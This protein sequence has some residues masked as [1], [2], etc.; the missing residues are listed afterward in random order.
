MYVIC[1]GD[2]TPFK[3]NE[4]PGTINWTDSEPIKFLPEGLNKENISEIYVCGSWM[5]QSSQKTLYPAY[6]NFCRHHL[7]CERILQQITAVKT[8]TILSN[9]KVFS[10][11][12]LLVEEKSNCSFCVLNR[13]RNRH[14]TTVLCTLWKQRE[15]RS[16]YIMLKYLTIFLIPHTH[17][18]HTR[19]ESWKQSNNTEKYVWEYTENEPRHRHAS[20]ELRPTFRQNWPKYFTSHHSQNLLAITENHAFNIILTYTNTF[21]FEH[22][23]FL[24]FT[25]C[26]WTCYLQIFSVFIKISFSF[27]AYIHCCFPLN[28]F[29]KRHTIQ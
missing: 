8:W 21:L 16:P 23:L 20:L 24:A 5:N 17:V 11:M 1:D 25:S 18:K 27:Y 4:I 19:K 9:S 13:V 7:L 26:K 22:Y 29:W 10:Q 15:V 28:F 2:H 3:A 14:V 12:K 6:T